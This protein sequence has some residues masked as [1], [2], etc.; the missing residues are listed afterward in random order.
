MTCSRC[1]VEKSMSMSGVVVISS[2]RKGSKRRL[3]SIGS[4]PGE[5]EQ[6]GDDAV[7]RRAAS[8][9]RDAAQPGEPHQV[10]VDQEELAEAGLVDDVELF[11]QTGRDL[12]QI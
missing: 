9:A 4:T 6:V 10:P 7:R 3:C 2:C 12:G 5:A 1:A 8:L 11:L